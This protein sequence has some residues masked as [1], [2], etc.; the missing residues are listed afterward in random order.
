MT[1]SPDWG[2]RPPEATRF[3][4]NLA[5][6]RRNPNRMHE[7]ATDEK[8]SQQAEEKV[9]LGAEGG[10]SSIGGEKRVPPQAPDI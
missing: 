7:Q 4:L 3:F 2:D 6:E 8:V 1:G 10:E 5:F 9:N